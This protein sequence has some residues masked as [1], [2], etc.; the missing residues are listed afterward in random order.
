MEVDRKLYPHQ[1]KTR[2]EEG[3]TLYFSDLH[4]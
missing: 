2:S 3:E 4:V 1:A